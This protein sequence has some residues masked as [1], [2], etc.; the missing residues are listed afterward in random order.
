MTKNGGFFECAIHRLDQFNTVEYVGWQGYI[1]ASMLR[2]EIRQ[3]HLLL[4][5]F[6][7]VMAAQN[8]AHMSR[9]NLWQCMESLWLSRTNFAD[10]QK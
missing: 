2:W 4:T 5:C 10:L 3:S 6:R 1:D 7:F 8:G 9:D